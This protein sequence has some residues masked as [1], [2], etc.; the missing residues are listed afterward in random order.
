MWEKLGRPGVF[1]LDFRPLANPLCICADPDLAEFLTRASAHF[2]TSAP[3]SKIAIEQ[4][5]PILGHENLLNKTPRQTNASIPVVLGH[6]TTLMSRI[7]AAADTCATIR[8]DVLAK[9]FSADVS[10][11]LALGQDLQVQKS[12]DGEGV[13]SRFGLITTM[14][15]LAHLYPKTPMSRFEFIRKAKTA[16]YSRLFDAHALRYLKPF[17]DGDAETA[18]SLPHC[19]FSLTTPLKP[20][21]PAG[22]QSTLHQLR[23]FLFA[24]EDT[25]SSVLQWSIYELFKH[26]HVLHDV[27]SEHDAIL[28]P[29]PL[30]ALAGRN[31]PTLLQKLPYTTAVMKEVLRLHPPAA[32]SRHVPKGSNF[33]LTVNDPLSGKDV[34]M[35]LDGTSPT[36]QLTPPFPPPPKQDFYINHHIIGRSPLLW[37]PSAHIFSP[38]RFLPSPSPNNPHPTTAFR[39]FERGP[40]A[41]IGKY[42]ALLEIK[43]FLVALG[44]AYKSKKGL[45]WEKVGFRGVEVDGMEEVFDVSVLTHQPV[46]GMRGVWW[47]ERERGGEEKGGL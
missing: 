5:N 27:I 15:T 38:S 39:A 17:L 34:E 18:N 13:K 26:P 1:F 46:D 47:W 31:A 28:G 9:D 10:A 6:V 22:L 2:K 40:R 42:L 37:G 14:H 25:I 33:T 43:I 11:H 23:T 44:E 4:L 19:I 36:N 12:K 16:F 3:K 20:L 21:A 24:G 7:F 41:C 35:E 29:D 30:T 8:M 45:R 32:T